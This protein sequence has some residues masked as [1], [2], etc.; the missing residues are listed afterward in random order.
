MTSVVLKTWAAD[1]LVTPLAT[2]QAARSKAQWGAKQSGS[3][4][5]DVPEGQT[6]IAG[7]ALVSVEVDGQT[8]FGWVID[9]DPLVSRGPKATPQ[10]HL[11]GLGL[12]RLL[13]YGQVWGDDCP[14]PA[15]EVVFGWQHPEYDDSGWAA[16]QSYGHVRDDPWPSPRPAGYPSRSAEYITDDTDDGTARTI[17]FR[18]TYDL[19]SDTPVGIAVSEDDSLPELYIN[20]IRLDELESSGQYNWR[21]YRYQ[22]YT[23]CGPELT[24]AGKIVN[25]DIGTTDGML[26]P[27]WLLLALMAPAGDGEPTSQDHHIQISTNAST[28]GT[29]ELFVNSD[30]AGPVAF[31][32]TDS[33]VKSAIETATG[34]TCTVVKDSSS[35]HTWSVVFDGPALSNTT[36]IT[37]PRSIDLDGTVTQDIVV[38]GN[39]GLVARDDTSVRMQTDTTWSVNADT[40]DPGM[41][42]GQIVRICLEAIQARGTTD[43]DH[44]TLGFTDTLDS[45]GNA[46]PDVLLRI[47]TQDTTLG[48]VV[49][50]L[51]AMGMVFDFTFSGSMRLQLDGWV[52]GGRGTD[53]SA[54][55]V[56]GRDD[57]QIRELGRRFDTIRNAIRSVTDE[58]FADITDATSITAHGRREGTSADG[59]FATEAEANQYAST[60]LT[61][62]KDP[63]LVS[64]F[65]VR[66][67][68]QPWVD[69]WGEAD[70]ITCPSRT[71]DTTAM[72][73]VGITLEVKDHNPELTVR[74][75][76]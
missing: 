2:L 6:G 41:P 60:D 28:S 75:V 18:R 56:L 40:D 38:Q 58:G 71:S 42:V 11:E 5:C 69:G 57:I 32:A 72:R 45:A 1:D 17:R 52:E 50:L 34:D 3:G 14:K 44:V 23:V 19:A 21:D 25:D 51:E 30:I 31:D 47:P 13:D 24:I 59:P 49:T 61:N 76:S 27:A 43:L 65:A 26:N 9:T 8:V 63:Q 70:I 68:L 22:V 12:R 55:V 48:T 64:T 33:D 16:A 66:P 4:S 37:T 20:G 10:I 15:T 39:S 73:T 67:G 35:P 46:W 62:L 36:V 7:G 54:T 74:T 29:W 53:R